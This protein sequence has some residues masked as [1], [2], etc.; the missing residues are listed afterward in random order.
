MKDF[1]EKLCEKITQDG[2]DYRVVLFGD[3]VW[4]A[5]ANWFPREII[6]NCES[7]AHGSVIR[8]N[9][10]REQARDDFLITVDRAS[11][12]LSGAKPIPFV[13]SDK[14]DYLHIGNDLNRERSAKTRKE[15]Q[16]QRDP[17]AHAREEEDCELLCLEN[18]EMKAEERARKKVREA[19][20]S[21]RKKEMIHRDAAPP[22][23]HDVICGRWGNVNTHTGSVNF[24]KEARKLCERYES[25]SKSEKFIISAFLVEVVRERGGRF[26]RRDG[27]SMDRGGGWFEA[28]GNNMR[29]KA[30]HAIKRG[31]AQKSDER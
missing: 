23:P 3:H 7:I 25:S 14:A 5:C 1:H 12:F 11:A 31:D 21:T 26:L 18:D 10:H 13:D 15:K 29:I 28:D 20:E 6:L 16:L 22:R 4:S 8:N 17:E 30:I 9:W 24:R 19:E 27:P 2:G